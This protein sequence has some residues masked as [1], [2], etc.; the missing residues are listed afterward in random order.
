[1]NRID[2]NQEDFS[3]FPENDEELSEEEQ[4]QVNKWTRENEQAEAEERGRAEQYKLSEDLQ[5]KVLGML[6]DPQMIAEAS[7]LIKPKHFKIDTHKLCAEFIIGFFD[8]YKS[9]P[10][11]EIIVD[12]LGRLNADPKVKSQHVIEYTAVK[13]YYVPGTHEK[14]YLIDTLVDFRRTAETK[15][16]FKLTLDKS[17]NIG[18]IPSDLLANLQDKLQKINEPAKDTGF[19]FEPIA[20]TDFVARE[21]KREWLVKNILVAG[22]PVIVGGAK[23]SLKTSVLVDLAISLG[24][25]TPFLDRW[26][27]KQA[28]TAIIS[29]ESG[30]ATIQETANRICKSKEIKLA[31]NS[32]DWFFRLPK[33][34]KAEELRTLSQGLARGKYEYVIIDPLYLC[35]LAGSTHEAKNLFDMGGVLY[36]VGLAIQDAGCIPILCHHARKNIGYNLPELDDLSMAGVAEFA[37]QWILLGRRSRFVEA[38]GTHELYMCVGGSAGHSGAWGIDIHE[39]LLGEDFTGKKWQVQILSMESL[40]KEKEEKKERKKTE[41]KLSTLEAQAQRVKEFLVEQKTPQFKTAIKTK[42]KLR[43][44]PTDSVLAMLV[45]SGEVCE[46]DNKYVINKPRD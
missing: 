13:Q 35:L 27:T 25:G 23:K 9:V 11:D 7:G 3:E 10:S 39:G 32:T 38:T 21:Y 44:G 24:S 22:Q 36:E 31:D 42:C 37:R 41:R 34:S 29:G 20:S 17:K 12:H 46:I 43:S 28:K 45:E 1:M 8:K 26:E 5:R 40:E 30:E 33:L 4:E 14:Q 18:Y 6:T 2:E 19:K 15:A 16:L